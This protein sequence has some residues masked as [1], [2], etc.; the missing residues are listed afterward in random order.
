MQGSSVLT[1]ASHQPF[2]GA[3]PAQD[4]PGFQATG[5]TFLPRR[6]GAQETAAPAH[7]QHALA[8]QAGVTRL[9]R[10]MLGALGRMAN[11]P[12]KAEP[13][14]ERASEWLSAIQATGCS[15]LR[16]QEMAKPADS[17]SD[18]GPR[19][20]IEHARGKRSARAASCSIA[21]AH[22]G[23]ECQSHE[24]AADPPPG[25]AQ[26]SWPGDDR[27]VRQL[28]A[29]G[30]PTLASTFRCAQ[31]LHQLANGAYRHPGAIPF[32]AGEMQDEI[33]RLGRQCRNIRAGSIKQAPQRRPPSTSDGCP[34]HDQTTRIDQLGW[35]P[36]P[37]PPPAAS[38]TLV[39]VASTAWA[40][41]SKGV[42]VDL[43]STPPSD[44]K[45]GR[46]N[47]RLPLQR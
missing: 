31:S 23:G 21:A 25:A 8:H 35:P 32:G 27:P 15:G 46:T 3:L 24:H 13:G 47:H 2:P 7:R 12:A 14:F 4:A 33:N 17:S 5:H 38:P 11:R 6:A 26:L 22:A 43:E 34:C 44:R 20:G 30:I 39:Q 16:S 10:S 42:A 41:R 18:A 19:P 29:T 45:S 40:L 1:T 36:Q 9:E 28:P 37:L